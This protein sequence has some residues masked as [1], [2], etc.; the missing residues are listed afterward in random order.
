MKIS[1]VA[2]APHMVMANADGHFFLNGDGNGCHEQHLGQRCLDPIVAALWVRHLNT[3]LSLRGD[4]P[5]NYCFV[6]APDKQSVYWETLSSAPDHR[7]IQMILEQLDSRWYFDPLDVLR[8][9][10]TQ[11]GRDPYPKVDTH[12]NS[13]G[14]IQAFRGVLEKWKLNYDFEKLEQ[15]ITTQR[16]E[17]DL[18]IKMIPRV[19][20]VFL[21]VEVGKW[22]NH[23]AYDNGV[24]DNGRIRV[25]GNEASP[26]GGRIL[27]VGDSFSYR[28]AELATF[29]FREVYHFHGSFL[30]RGFIKIIQPD[31]FIFE[32]T[33][34]FFIQAPR[35]GFD[36]SFTRLLEE[37][38][39]NGVDVDSSIERH[40]ILQKNRV[41][42]L[43]QAFVIALAEKHL[44]NLGV[45]TERFI[46]NGFSSTLRAI[47]Q[48]F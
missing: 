34:R 39:E 36:S 13:L 12:W 38:I 18:G 23:L 15:L 37:K 24:P 6:P 22:R 17:G 35:F 16:S 43:N 14:A 29:I 44:E 27:I 40:R 33:E 32:Q 25:F 28:L 11:E 7:N 21:N 47:K 5:F 42:S 8:K 9:L 1:P 48:S 20:D 45:V 2:D 10:R 4:R 19:S 26:C 46:P 31:Y 41:T 3:I 30:D